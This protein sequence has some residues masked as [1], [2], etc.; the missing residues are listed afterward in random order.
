VELGDRLRGFVRAAL[1]QAGADHQ[2]QRSR[3][4]RPIL[5]RQTSEVALSEICGGGEISTIEYHTR[6]PERSERMGS[7]AL[8]QR[9]GFVK[10]SLAPP[11]FSE[12][13]E[14][15]PRHGRAACRE[16]IGG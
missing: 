1:G 14:P 9:H 16:L 2:L 6:A 7:T 4:L 11:Q 3:A 15:F 5:H 10:P 12:T 13:H 8:E